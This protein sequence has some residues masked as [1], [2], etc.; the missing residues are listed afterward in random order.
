MVAWAFG[1]IDGNQHIVTRGKGRLH[2]TE[3]QSAPFVGGERHR[4]GAELLKPAA[5]DGAAQAWR[6]KSD[7]SASPRPLMGG[8]GDEIGF[9]PSDA[10]HGRR[11]QWCRDDGLGWICDKTRVAPDQPAARGGGVSQ[12]GRGACHRP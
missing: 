6:H 9:M 1:S 10:D 12:R 2:L 8:D 5:H 11:R 7:R 4:Y 3:A